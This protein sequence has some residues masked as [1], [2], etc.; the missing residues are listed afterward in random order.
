MGE[1]ILK[2]TVFMSDINGSKMFARTWKMMR[3]VIVQD[4]TEQMIMLIRYGIW[5][6]LVKMC[7]EKGLNFGPT[8]GFSTMTTL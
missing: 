7:V 2:S 5:C 4:L 8:I 6:I 1:K 3:E